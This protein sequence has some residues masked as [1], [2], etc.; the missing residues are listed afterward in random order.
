M[1]I[2]NYFPE[3]EEKKFKKS[4]IILEKRRMLP[5]KAKPIFIFVFFS[6]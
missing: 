6:N 2:K 1:I 5:L 3:C 4:I